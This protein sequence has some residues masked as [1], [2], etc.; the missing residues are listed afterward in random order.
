MST[1]LETATKISDNFINLGL[2]ALKG[3]WERVISGPRGHGDISLTYR[4]ALTRSRVWGPKGILFVTVNYDTDN[5]VVLAHLV[6]EVGWEL[7]LGGVVHSGRLAEWEQE[8][9]D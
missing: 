5:E 1:F 8:E 3:K 2:D 9:D 4:V 6:D 7:T